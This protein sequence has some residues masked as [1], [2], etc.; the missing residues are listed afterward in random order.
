MNASWNSPGCLASLQDKLTRSSLPQ[1]GLQKK[2]PKMG[3]FSVNSPGVTPRR[4]FFEVEFPIYPYRQGDQDNRIS[5]TPIE[6]P[7]PT[8]PNPLLLAPEY[9]ETLESRKYRNQTELARALNVTP[10]RINQ[11]LRLLKLP[12]KVQQSVIRM[13][14]L[15]SPREITERRLRTLLSSSQSK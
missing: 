2:G 3:P 13:G 9:K 11:Y 12:P 4:L 14:D 8:Y 5:L 10:S 6:K 1:K 7:Q 15:S